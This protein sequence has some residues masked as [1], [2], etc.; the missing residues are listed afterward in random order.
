L[1]GGVA[2]AKYY[3]GQTI[4]IVGGTGVGQARVILSYA[5]STVATVTRDWAVAPDN[6]SEFMVLGTDVAAILEAGTAQAGGVATITLDAGASAISNT[7]KN[8]FIMITGGTGL[9]QTRLISA[10][11]GG[12][13]VATILPNWTTTPDAT[14]VYQVLPAARVDV[15]GWAGAL[16]TLSSNNRPNVNI[17]EVSDDETA[18]SNLE[19]DYDGT[20]Y[21]KA[22]STIGTTTTNTD[23]RGTDGANTTVPDAAGVAAALHATTDA[24]IAALNNLSAGDVNSQVVDALNVDTY[25]EP[26]TG[27]PPAEPTIREMAHYL[28]KQF[29]NLERQTAT[30]YELMADDG[31]T[32][33]QQATVSSDGTTFTKQELVSG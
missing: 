17:A 8:N 10:Y 29:R 20:G 15:G 21:A 28:Y 18:A 4:I 5:A 26:G 23:M 19:L 13:K 9:G 32:V 27:A 25:S 3:N 31:V 16:A 24:L 14:S 30:L 12:T 1:T 6:T 7:Y 11:N 33:D 22:N 2:T